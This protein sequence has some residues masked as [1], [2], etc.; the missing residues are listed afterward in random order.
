MATILYPQEETFNDITS[1]VK[2]SIKLM[3]CKRVGF[4]GNTNSAALR[5]DKISNSR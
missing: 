2:F 5:L 1:L 3:F 4:V